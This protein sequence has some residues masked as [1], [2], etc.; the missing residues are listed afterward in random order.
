MSFWSDK[1]VLVTGGPGF[2][3]RH[4][5]RR[6]EALSPRAIAAPSSREYDLVEM[7]N[8]VRLYE[9]ARP[10]IVIHLAGRVGGIGANRAN[11]GRFLYENLM[12]GVQLIEIARR[13]AVPKVVIAGTICAYPKFTPAPFKEEDLWNG[14]PEETNAPYGLAK[15]MLLAQAQ[16]YREQY[17]FN[18]IFL[19]P[20]NLYGPGDNFDLQ[21][22]HVIPA[23]IR[24]CVEAI[25]R[26]DKTITLW[27]TGTPTREFLYVTDAVDGLL[28]A[29]ESY[30]G[31][32]PVNLG[33]GREI[34][35]ADLAAL[36]AKMTGFTGDL[37]WDSNQP[38]GQPRRVLDT[39]RAEQLFGFRAATPF[40]EGLRETIAWYR[41]H[42][43]AAAPPA[44]SSAKNAAV[45]SAEPRT[46][47]VLVT[48]SLFG[49]VDPAPRDLLAAN[50]LDVT[51]N[52]FGRPIREDELADL[53][54]ET[55]A[56]IAGTE[57][58]TKKVLDR[59][60]NLKLI[61]RVGIGLDSVALREARARGIAV[62]YTPDAPS[63]AVA[64]FTIGQMI[65]LLRHTPTAHRALKQGQW[66]RMIGRRIGDS[67]VGVIGTGRIGRLVI[68]YLQAWRPRRILAHDLAPDAAFARLAGC[69]YTDKE[70][71]LR[72]ADVVTVHVPRTAATRSLIG[73]AELASM[74]SDA[75]LI[76]T[77]RGGI[78][79]EAAL[80]AALRARAAF[81]AAIDVFEHE[82]YTGDLTTLENCL[83]SCHMGSAARDARL[84]MEL[85]AAQ[86]VVR[87][88]RGEP[89][90]NP[91]SDA[92]YALDM[93]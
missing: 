79:D 3:G 88:F 91:I 83:L 22:S 80:A 64:E 5:L 74:K 21:S 66:R 15:K 65:A 44:A 90:A 42:R 81:S 49:D 55:E 27:G 48:T 26:G 63:A 9:D 29:S 51:L 56:L 68:R 17:G 72:E 52:P 8:V 16:A 59:A 10:D 20:V 28:R 13:M 34:R 67:T 36:I 6:L 53:V 30:D 84:R 46:G 71:L 54:G 89:L 33:S 12:M 86:E 93:F 39:S 50:G 35:I 40:E 47:K 18:A 62:S 45:A 41:E 23:L 4:F 31:P 77:S 43:S 75:V 82:P 92:D 85:E 24:K 69:E 70:T 7:G 60:P 78:V 57:P 76:N 25:D 32:E 73:A 87:F 37:I 38:D 61:A 19:L 58:I 2:L 14:Y 1:R 11:P